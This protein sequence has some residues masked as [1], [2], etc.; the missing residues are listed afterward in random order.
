MNK[1][2]LLDRSKDSKSLNMNMLIING[3]E[4]IVMDSI[5]SYK[6]ETST[7]NENNNLIL[8]LINNKKTFDIIRYLFDYI[9]KYDS[10]KSA[11]FYS[12]IEFDNNKETFL[13]KGC[14][15]TNYEINDNTLNVEIM[16]DLLSL[17]TLEAKKSVRE[18]KLKKLL[19]K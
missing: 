1:M 14:L 11:K 4:L 15:I 6:L 17:D 2:L 12:L 18:L 5:I 9:F 16:F 8:T 7:Y 19:N 10:I 13:L 3:D